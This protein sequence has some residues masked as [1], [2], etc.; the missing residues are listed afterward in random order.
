MSQ[1]KSKLTRRTLF[2]GAGTAGAAA[3]VAT[4]VPALEAAPA[5][6]ELSQPMPDKG[7]G[8]SLTAHVRRYYQTARI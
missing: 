5:Q 6:P 3:A 1:P 2:A 4:L 7:G 8:Y